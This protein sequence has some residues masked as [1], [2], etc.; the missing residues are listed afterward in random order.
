V[1]PLIEAG[2]LQPDGDDQVAS[3]EFGRSVALDP[4]P[5]GEGL[6]YFCPEAGWQPVSSA[7]LRRYRVN[8]VKLFEAMMG[9]VAPGRP[10]PLR[11]L[12]PELLWEFG[13]VRLPGTPRTAILVV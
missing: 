13:D 4:S 2:L 12:I 11:E 6:G 8:S 3:D 9:K 10:Q 1:P 5:A 7:R